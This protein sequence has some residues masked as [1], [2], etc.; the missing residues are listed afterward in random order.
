MVFFIIK[1]NIELFVLSCFLLMFARAFSNERLNKV[2]N[3]V[4]K[5]VSYLGGFEV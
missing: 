4:L 1:D 5:I 3:N 2:Q